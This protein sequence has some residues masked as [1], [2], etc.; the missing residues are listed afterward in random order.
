MK[1]QHTTATIRKATED[2]IPALVGLQR[3]IE[4]ENAIWGYRA[5]AAETW[6]ERDLS[7]TLIAVAGT[8]PVGFVYCAPRPCTGECVF[9]DGGKVLEIVDLAV[10]QE[11]R[12]CGLG[13]QLVAAIEQRA[14]G[15]GFTHL[16]LYSAA[17]RFD[18]I[19]RFYR[20]SGFTPWYLEMAKEIGAESAGSWH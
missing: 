1:R 3:A 6:A 15:E 14:S 4:A 19:L 16:R 7:W 11:H 2:D 20:D 8:Q 5:D 17:K 13:H 10:V 9:P 18:E 12:H